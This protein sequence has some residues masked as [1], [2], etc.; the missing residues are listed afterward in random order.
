MLDVDGCHTTFCRLEKVICLRGYVVENYIVWRL[1]GAG[2]LMLA[3]SDDDSMLERIVG[4]P[5]F[6]GHNLC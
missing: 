6:R 2:P 4:A 5:F 3:S 1:S